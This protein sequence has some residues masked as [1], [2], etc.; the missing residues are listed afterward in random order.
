MILPY[1]RN[2]LSAKTISKYF[3]TLRIFPDR[4]YKPRLNDVVVNWGFQG[5]IPV[6]EGKNVDILNKSE[7][8]RKASSKVDCLTILGKNGVNV[9]FFATDL[10]NAKS[11]FH[12][13]ENIFCRTLTRASKGKGIVIARAEDQ[14]VKCNLYTSMLDTDIEY[15][16]HVFDG[17]VIDI[18]QKRQM[19]KDR[20]RDKGIIVANKEVK[21]L[22]NGWSFTRGDLT[23]WDKDGNYFYDM[24]SISLNAIKA[25]DL[26]FAAI[27][28]VKTKDDEFYVLEVNTAPGM[29]RG[30]TTHRRYTEAISKYCNIPFDHDAYT[31]RYGIGNTHENNLHD[32][33]T[34]YNN[35]AKK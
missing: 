23:L 35:L 34:S 15:R 28:L 6:L 4:N 30:T 31:R 17:E 20:M 7:A 32:F 13:S 18:V 21:N 11:L 12:L 19:S 26:D 14:L 27:D 2:S 9:P 16:V 33:I 25:L 24:I 1:K 3:K 8:V 22:M 29:K 10:E 5:D